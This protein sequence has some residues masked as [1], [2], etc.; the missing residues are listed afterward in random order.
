MTIKEIS[1]LID[2]TE[3]TVRRWVSILADKTSPIKD[4]MSVSSP[5]NPADFTLDET[6][7]ILRAGKIS[8]GII[9]LL[10]ENA[11]NKKGVQNGLLLSQ[12]EYVMKKSETKEIVK[13]TV[14][15]IMKGIIPLI[16][17]QAKKAPAALPMVPEKS[18]SA[19]INQIVRTYA[20]NHELDYSNVWKTL[21]RELYYHFQIDVY[22][23]AKNRGMSKMDYIREE[24][25][26]KELLA[27][28]KKI[29]QE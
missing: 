22:K 18:P 13:D 12:N 24:G 27:L 8:E 23:R 10:R 7:D 6:I 20:Q 16:M 17:E 5:N 11:E 26:E 28:A 15:E 21:Y 3:R 14:S 2:K 9:S 29:F 19:E 4:K 25:I 1:I